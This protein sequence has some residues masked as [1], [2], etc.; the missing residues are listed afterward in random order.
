MK[1]PV[2]RRLAVSAIA[3]LCGLVALPAVAAT[4]LT[5]A[6]NLPPLVLSAGKAFPKEPMQLETGKYYRWT[7]ECDGTSEM[8]I[9]APD[10]F[11]F[12]W[13]NEIV[14]NKI[15]IRPLGLHSIE[16]DAKGAA[17]ISFVPIRPG[18]FEYFMPN[19]K[20]DAF[21]GKIIVK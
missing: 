2:M 6:T 18:E 17:T 21:R 9:A 11:R 19:S 14:I 10:F 8:G 5:K 3:L 15:E 4:L 7:I 12:I 20:G 13:I 16:F 1:T